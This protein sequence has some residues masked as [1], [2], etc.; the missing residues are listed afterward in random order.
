MDFNGLRIDRGVREVVVD[1]KVVPL[2]RLEFDLLAHLASRPRQVFSR[3][4]LLS[5][6][7]HSSPDWQT[8]KT[9]T[10]HVRRIRHKIEPSR[11]RPRWI[12]T[13]P[14]AGYR[15]EP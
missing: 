10:E 12:R 3:G 6:V 9:V 1:E 8:S 13:V 5:E 11:D 14:G 15:F 7:W 2:T 4:E